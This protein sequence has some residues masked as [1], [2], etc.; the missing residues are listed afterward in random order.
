MSG[1]I[2]QLH[3]MADFF[4]FEGFL[5]HVEVEQGNGIYVVEFKVP[6]LPLWCLLTDREC[7]IEQGAVL[8]ICRCRRL[9]HAQR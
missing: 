6:I 1:G 8:E 9:P 5:V 3:T 7:G 4:L 2:A